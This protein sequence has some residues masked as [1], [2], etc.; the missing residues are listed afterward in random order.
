[1]N[2]FI[3]DENFEECAEYH[4][5]KHIVKM[6][7]EAAQLL[8][9]ALWV[10]EYLGFIP[11]ALDKHERETL[12]LARNDEPRPFPY[13]PSYVNHPC[14][15]WARS[16]LDNWHWL[17]CYADALGDEYTYRYGKIHKSTQVIRELPDPRNMEQRGMRPMPQA[18][19]DQY[20]VDNTV[21]AYRNYYVGAKSH[22]A[23]WKG[24]EKPE[25][26]EWREESRKEQQKS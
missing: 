15:I 14:A 13:L 8:C 11:R 9:S 4:V 3:L 10:D 22:L 12:T 6:P 19:P 26:F 5:D 16:S 18:M 21:E 7:L 2:I 17:W 20:K 23:S 1:M 24:R 25:W